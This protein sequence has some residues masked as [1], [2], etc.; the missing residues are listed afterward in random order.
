M[1][2]EEYQ[3]SAG[4]DS[5]AVTAGGA[6]ARSIAESQASAIGL[7]MKARRIL[8]IRR[9]EKELIKLQKRYEM[10]TDPQYLADMKQ[11]LRTMEQE[12]KEK[13]DL[14]NK[15]EIEQVLL[16]KRIQKNA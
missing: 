11:Q 8:Q 4:P 1:V 2:D 12:R 16:D 3:A 7:S 6:D 15:L 5:E 10:V 13:T 9:I 14:I